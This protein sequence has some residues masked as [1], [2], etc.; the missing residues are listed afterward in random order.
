MMKRMIIRVSILC[1]AAGFWSA[2]LA[3][4]EDWPCW[5]GPTGC[6]NS[7]ARN[8]PVTWNAK[9]NLNVLWK[10]ELPKTAGTTPSSPIVVG[11]SVIVTT[12][13]DKPAL[14]H[15]V[16][17]YSK[18]DGGLRW[19]TAVPPGPMKQIDGRAG[20]SA[21]TPCSDGRYVFALF[22]S[23]VMAGVD[24][25]D[26]QLKWRQELKDTAFDCALGNSPMVCGDTI[27]F[28][29]DQNK[30]R[31][32]VYGWDC[33]TGTL[34]FEEKRPSEIFCHS[35]PI[36]MK[37]D[38]K[39]QMIYA[40]NKATQGLDPST[41]KV[42]WWA[43]WGPPNNW[44]GESSSPVHGGGLIYTDNGRGGGGVALIPGS[45]GDVS[46]TNVKAKFAV[47]SDIGSPIIVGD[48]VYRNSGDRVQCLKL[49][50][51]EVIYSQPLA[52][53]QAWASPVATADRVYYATAGKSYVLKAG[54]AFEIIGQG[55][56]NDGNP[57]SPA[58]SDDKLYL[59]GAKY[60]WCVGEKK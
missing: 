7:D 16:A 56:L 20:A 32:A 58:I 52:G 48:C 9:D 17:C 54:P 53:L 38:G 57:S 34:K 30:G 10:A 27:L 6:G 47:K 36:F 39:D 2:T 5:R 18:T 41:G 35:T 55:D 26:G 1:L 43:T 40:G 13:A 4:A 51:G 24:L 50:S 29:A 25:K 14:E 8:L 3:R 11:D 37:I 15:H 33:R 60:L 49:Q 31:S 59:K 12:S 23:C 45:T 44:L 21:P 22:G 42:L 28:V 19:A 46:R